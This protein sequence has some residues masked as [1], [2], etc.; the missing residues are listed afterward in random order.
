MR[1]LHS[2]V[3][4]PVRF[5]DGCRTAEPAVVMNECPFLPRDCERFTRAEVSA[6]VA[7]DG[8]V[9]PS[10]VGVLRPATNGAGI[11]FSRGMHDSFPF[12]FEVLFFAIGFDSP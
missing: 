5:K 1:L 12:F 9:R 7:K 4:F 11:L 8:D 10:A 2:P 3:A 6:C